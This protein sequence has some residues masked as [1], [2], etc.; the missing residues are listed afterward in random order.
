VLQPNEEG[1]LEI[2]LDTSKF[3]GPRRCSLL[4]HTEN[5]KKTVTRFIIAANALDDPES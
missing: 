2:S 4:L 3:R 5:G 1:Q